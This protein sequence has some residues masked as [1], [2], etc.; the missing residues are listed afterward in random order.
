MAEVMY[1]A[2]LRPALKDVGRVVVTSHVN[3]DGDAIAGVLALSASLRMARWDVQAVLPSPVPTS[4]QFLPGWESVAVY[5][6]EI[7]ESP[8]GVLAREA[9]LSAEAI[10]C[11]DASDTSRLG[12]VYSHHP[13]KFESTPVVN[14]D[15]HPTNLRFGSVNLVDPSAAAV[16]EM[17]TLLMGEEDLPID[18]EV[19]FSL[20]VGIVA[21]T[22]N[23]RTSATSP[24]TLRAAAALMERG[25]SLSQISER[26]FN[27]RSPRTLRLWGRVLSRARVEKGLVWADITGQMLD[28]CQAT[29]E[30]AD[31]LVDFIAGVPE[32]SAAFLFSEQEGKV[33]VSMRTSGDLDAAALARRFGGGGHTRAA[34]CTVEGTMSEVQALLMGEAWRQLE[35]V[36]ARADGWQDGGS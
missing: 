8:E 11:L 16:C 33:R 28:E 22:L 25:V 32:T 31:H 36:A 18:E 1:S 26:I 23:F 35:G 12:A 15:H 6:P 34:G 5:S 7:A 3:P 27:T 14:L 29:L 24:R 13:R 30:D 21:D 9:L 20:L 4:Y 19:A 2:I 17:L 10:L